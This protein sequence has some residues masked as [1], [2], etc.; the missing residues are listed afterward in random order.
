MLA[1]LF[2]WAATIVALVGTVLNCKQVRACFYL[3]LVTNAM[4]FAWD[5]AH[6]LASRA[7]LDVVQFVLA[8]YGIYEWRRLDVEVDGRGIRGAEEGGRRG[9]DGFRGSHAK[10]GH[11]EKLGH[12]QQWRQGRHV[13][14]SG[15]RRP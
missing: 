8:G 5:V 7:L 10:V 12:R 1:T 11:E 6:D 4:W 9:R 13:A 2:S 15:G 3:W 14:G